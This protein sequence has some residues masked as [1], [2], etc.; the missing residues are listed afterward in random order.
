MNQ[1]PDLFGCAVAQVGVMDM[2]KFHKFTIGHAWTTDFG[3]SEIKDQFEWLIKSVWHTLPN[4]PVF[5]EYRLIALRSCTRIGSV[6]CHACVAC[7]MFGMGCKY[8]GFVDRHQI[9]V[10]TVV[11]QC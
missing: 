11:P 6:Y 9:N 10:G 3:C 4:P 8:T 2:L 7:V 1:R 5:I